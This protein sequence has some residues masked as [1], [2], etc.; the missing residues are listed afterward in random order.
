MNSKKHK[1]YLVKI[2]G[3]VNVTIE[4]PIIEIKIFSNSNPNHFWNS[5]KKNL[6][7]V[8]ERI[9]QWKYMIM[10]TI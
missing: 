2:I 6:A 9:Y 10:I 5:I 3:K 8:K 4:K 1:K 7:L